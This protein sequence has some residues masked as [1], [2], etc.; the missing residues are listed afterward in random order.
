V[1][2]DA[3]Q[4]SRKAKEIGRGKRSD[5]SGSKGRLGLVVPW[6]DTIEAGAGVVTRERRPLLLCCTRGNRETY[7]GS[8]P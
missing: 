6:V 4:I 2:F 7:H 1:T 3:I 5:S 8:A